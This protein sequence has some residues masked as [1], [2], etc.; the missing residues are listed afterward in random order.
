MWG[1]RRWKREDGGGV[2]WEGKWGGGGREGS[3]RWEEGKADMWWSVNYDSSCLI[4]MLLHGITVKM[5]AKSCLKSIF[6]RSYYNYH[7]ETNTPQARP[8]TNNA[9]TLVRTR[10]ETNSL[11]DKSG[12]ELQSR[13][14]QRQ[15]PPRCGG[16]I[17]SRNCW[18]FQIWS[19]HLFIV[20]KSLW[21]VSNQSMVKQAKKHGGFRL[22]RGE[23]TQ[24]IP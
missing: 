23:V 6:S 14:F 15:T 22:Q 12:E 5:E 18:Y 2:R 24:E 21:P 7:P 4:K 17:S 10:P 9:R 16:V 1:G 8:E 19:L 3:E 13:H 11:L 20:K